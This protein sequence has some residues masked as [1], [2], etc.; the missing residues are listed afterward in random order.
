MQKKKKSAD[1]RETFISKGTHSDR[2]ELV[3]QV[4]NLNLCVTIYYNAMV[5]HLKDISTAKL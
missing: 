1:Q 5:T 3:I 2:L 4:Y